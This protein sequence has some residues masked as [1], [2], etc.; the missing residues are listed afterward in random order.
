ME[1]PDSTQI[2]QL[3]TFFSSYNLEDLKCPVSGK[4]II[5]VCVNPKA[6]R[7]TLCSWCLLNDPDFIRKYRNDLL[8]IEDIRQKLEEGLKTFER[9]DPAD[10]LDDLSKIKKKVKESLL[11]AIDQDF[12]AYFEKGVQE[13][14]KALDQKL[15][16]AT[17]TA[18]QSDP[19][20]EQW[21][22]KGNEAI[23]ASLSD[24]ATAVSC[25][26]GVFNEI[27]SDSL[28]RAKLV[29]S[30]IINYPSKDLDSRKVAVSNE[31]QRLVQ[32]LVL[33]MITSLEVFPLFERSCLLKRYG[34]LNH[35][36]NYQNTLNSLCFMVS[37]ET[38]FY[39][40]S[41]YF[42]TGQPIETRFRLV[43]GD[44]ASGKDV[45]LDFTLT[46]RPENQGQPER[47]VEDISQR[48]YPVFFEKPVMLKPQVWYNISFN[49][50]GQ[51]HHIYYGTG[52]L[53]GT[54]ERFN[55]AEGRKSV[56]FRR[57]ADDTLDNSHNMGQFPDFYLR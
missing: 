14:Q 23:E 56:S 42:T 45:V 12:D 21:L 20:S 34:T 53:S 37:E 18:A 7:K 8:P 46:I 5:A 6:P 40:Y 22:A 2:R 27:S 24:P 17:E 26:I 13:V 39:G 36:Y 43:E 32:L 55:F 31:V 25:I 57:A 3:S 50:P 48:T 49:K 33:K 10:V 41:Q 54:G 4:R 52:P 19:Q 11:E 29:A 1:R 15:T 30:E 16:T 47:T 35:A 51:S 44:I 38:I 28:V 9:A